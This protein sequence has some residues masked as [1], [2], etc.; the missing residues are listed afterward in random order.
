MSMPATRNY[1]KLRH[2][3]LFCAMSAFTPLICGVVTLTL[4]IVALVVIFVVEVYLALFAARVHISLQSNLEWL[5]NDFT[6]SNHHE[7]S[8]VVVATVVAIDE[9]SPTTRAVTVTPVSATI[10]PLHQISK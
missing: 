5:T 4:V 9:T 2:R 3:Q 7:T 8:V 6:I 1:L 10:L